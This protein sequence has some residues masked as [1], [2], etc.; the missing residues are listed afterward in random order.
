MCSCSG[1]RFA[2]LVSHR[3]QNAGLAAVECDIE[4][5]DFSPYTIKHD[6]STYREQDALE[7]W[8]V[9]NRED[10]R[11]SGRTISRDEPTVFNS[12]HIFA[13]EVTSRL[14]F[15]KV[16]KEVGISANGIMID[17]QRIIVV[18]VNLL[19]ALLYIV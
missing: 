5:L 1:Y 2:S 10:G 4:I 18:S 13:G 12:P 7:M 3:L 16:V 15:R 6:E 19:S 17:D 9:L 8:T 11:V 14:P